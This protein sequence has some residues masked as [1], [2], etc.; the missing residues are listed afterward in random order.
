MGFAYNT[1]VDHTYIGR[2]PREA[3]VSLNYWLHYTKINPRIFFKLFVERES[4]QLFRTKQYGFLLSAQ[5]LRYISQYS[6]KLTKKENILHFNHLN[7][8]IYTSLEAME[9]DEQ[10]ESLS[11]YHCF[12]KT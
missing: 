4:L 5:T 6:K 7:K 3:F 1:I 9:K 10:V 8:I 12:D 11:I 2:N